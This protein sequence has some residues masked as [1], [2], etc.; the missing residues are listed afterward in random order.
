MMGKLIGL[1]GILAIG[2]AV[3][4]AAGSGWG[5]T[6]PAKAQAPDNVRCTAP[7]EATVYNGANAGF[8]MLGT[9]DLEVNPNGAATGR[10]LRPGS[11]E[12][13]PVVGQVAGRSVSLV[14]D[15]GDAGVIVGVGA[16]VNN[17]SECRGFVG[18][19]FSGPGL[20]DS[21]DWVYICR[22]RRI[23]EC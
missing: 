17:L 21:G 16:G 7:F 23:S 6:R 18:G 19:T 22:A 13:I 15:L 5:A 2:V 4:F 14:F 3:L 8:A 20:G 12:V 1:G 10:V 11:D 9:L